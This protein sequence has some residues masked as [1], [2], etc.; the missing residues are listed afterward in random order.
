VDAIR[1]VNSWDEGEDT[2]SPCFIATA[3]YGTL[4]INQIFH[5]RKW[6]DEK[7]HNK[8]YGRFLINVYYKISPPISKYISKTYLRKKI[9]RIFLKPIILCHS[10]VFAN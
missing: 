9:V 7:L 8:N 6:R 2:N 10:K 4:L 5:L 1:G 3:V